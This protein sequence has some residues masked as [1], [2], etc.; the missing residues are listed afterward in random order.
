MRLCLLVFALVVM[1]CSG[2]SPPPVIPPWPDATAIEK[3]T[4]TVSGSVS[5]EPDLAEFEV[6]QEYFAALLRVLGPPKFYEHPPAKYLREVGRLC[7]ACRDGRS[8]E[9]TLIYYGHGQVLYRFQGVPCSRGGSYNDLLPS[10][11]KF[12]DE[13]LTLEG[14]L[15]A[16]QSSD[17]EGAKKYLE[18]LDKSAGRTPI[19]S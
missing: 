13:L 11:G 18:L 15:R 9:V 1:G 19:R 3:I 8:L 7:F 2:S 10:K 12:V 4:A 16:V 6:P 14:V 17:R 5:H